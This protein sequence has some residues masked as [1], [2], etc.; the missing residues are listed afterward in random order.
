M[1]KIIKKNLSELSGLF[2]KYW[3][4]LLLLLIFLM[5][6]KKILIGV[7]IL[8]M[9]ITGSLIGL[10]RKF[11]P[12]NLGLELTTFF[13]IVLCFA[14][15]PF[16]AWIIAV[17]IIL[18]THFVTQNICF[19][20]VIKI[21]VYGLLCLLVVLLSGLGLPLVGMIL[22]VLKNI[23]FIIITFMMSPGKGTIDLPSNIINTF[24]NI[25]LFTAWAGLL[26]SVF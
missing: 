7:V 16:Y 11:I 19:F 8:L 5:L 14:L 4:L 3:Y 15:N 26:L 18:G 22:A 24:V 2:V 1:N 17:L 12:F 21:A 10:Y 23:I 6:G 20:I 9:I 13:T 25:Y